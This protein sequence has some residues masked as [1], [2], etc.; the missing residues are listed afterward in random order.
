MFHDV[1]Y[2]ESN[3]YVAPVLVVV[4]L[5]VSKIPLGPIPVAAWSKAW[6]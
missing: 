5:T 1:G 4:Q 2:P 6:V 3:V